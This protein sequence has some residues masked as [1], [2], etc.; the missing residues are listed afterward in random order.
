[1]TWLDA[2]RY[3]TLVGMPFGAESE[4]EAP[5]TRDLREAEVGRRCYSTKSGIR[6]DRVISG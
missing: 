3:S 4:T 2:G 1:M 6:V 5:P